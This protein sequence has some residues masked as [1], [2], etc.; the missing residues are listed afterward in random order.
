MCIRDSFHGG[1]IPGPPLDGEAPH[2]PVEPAHNGIVEQLLLGHEKDGP[3]AG[4]HQKGDIQ[5]G[6]VVAAEDKSSLLGDIL[7]PVALV[8]EYH[9]GQGPA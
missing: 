1:C 7:P 6:G 2:V 3:L 5:I 9:A 8:P 4:Q